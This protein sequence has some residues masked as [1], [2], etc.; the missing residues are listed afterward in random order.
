MILEMIIMVYLMC[1]YICHYSVNTIVVYKLWM[2]AV[3]TIVSTPLTSV[4]VDSV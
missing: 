2:E 1:F 4:V 3:D